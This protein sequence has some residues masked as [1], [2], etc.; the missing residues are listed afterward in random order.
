MSVQEQFL[1]ATCGVIMALVMLAFGI[2]FLQ[3]REQWIEGWAKRSRWRP[4]RR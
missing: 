3:R 1:A 2:D 4:W